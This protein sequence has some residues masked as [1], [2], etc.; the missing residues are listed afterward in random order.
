ME[1]A[2]ARRSS[3]RRLVGAIAVGLLA[4]LAYTFLRMLQHADPDVPRAEA[5][6]L[7]DTLARLARSHPHLFGGMT[8][9]T[10]GR[11]SPEQ[12]VGT[13]LTAGQADRLRRMQ[14]VL[15]AEAPPDLFPALVAACRA[16]LVGLGP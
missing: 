3:T 16:H 4:L 7:D 9:H 11:V 10:A 2:A 13:E 15:R 12:A 14:A 5:E 6:R 8:L 1:R